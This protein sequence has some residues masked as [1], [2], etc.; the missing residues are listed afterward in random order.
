M[1][2]VG[3]GDE[4]FARTRDGRIVR[5]TDYLGNLTPEGRVYIQTERID[6]VEVLK[7]EKELRDYRS[8]E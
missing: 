4:S 3:D 6:R 1:S 5:I 7:L 8:Q 2:V